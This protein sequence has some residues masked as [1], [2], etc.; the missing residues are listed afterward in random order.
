M[1]GNQ[2][3]K[4]KQERRALKKTDLNRQG[5]RTGGEGNVTTQNLFLAHENTFKAAQGERDKEAE[6]GDQ[7]NL[8]TQ[9][10][11]SALEDSYWAHTTPKGKVTG[12]NA[13]KTGDERNPRPKVTIPVQKGRRRQG[14]RTRDNC[15][16]AGLKEQGRRKQTREA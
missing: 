9:K 15:K 4:R 7:R 12:E 16:S 5:R 3:G 10:L 1:S 14:R 13:E 6:K 11:F 2:E 8:K